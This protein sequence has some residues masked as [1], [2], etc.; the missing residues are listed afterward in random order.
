MHIILRSCILPN[1]LHFKDIAR[2]LFQAM[3]TTQKYDDIY[4]HFDGLKHCQYCILDGLEYNSNAYCQLFDNEGRKWRWLYKW[5]RQLCK[6]HTSRWNLIQ[7]TWYFVVLFDSGVVYKELHVM[8]IHLI[9]DSHC[10]YSFYSC[11][12]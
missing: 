12:V 9:S 4:I 7:T 5:L 11:F 2:K 8:I 1:R 3:M 10:L 6:E